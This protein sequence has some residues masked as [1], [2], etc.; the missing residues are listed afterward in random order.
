MAEKGGGLPP[1]LERSGV[2][3]VNIQQRTRQLQQTTQRP[4]QL[5]NGQPCKRTNWNID[6]HFVCFL[7]SES[8]A[9]FIFS[10]YVTSRFICCRSPRLKR[11]KTENC[12]KCSL[13]WQWKTPKTHYGFYFIINKS[14]VNSLNTYFQIL[15]NIYKH[16]N[17]YWYIPTY[18]NSKIYRHYYEWSIGTRSS[19]GGLNYTFLTIFDRWR[20]DCSHHGQ[21]YTSLQEECIM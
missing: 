12:G 9:S 13:A 3:E 19:G 14:D 11:T 15:I 10:F 7:S 1:G 18:S 5:Q 8:V 2:S 16:P 21:S 6:F 4:C 17:T 20:Y